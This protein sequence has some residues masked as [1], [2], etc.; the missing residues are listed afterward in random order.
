MKIFV[1]SLLRSVERR[2]TVS[3]VMADHGLDFEFIDG[4]DGKEGSHP[5]LKKFKPNKFLVRHGRP[6]NPGEGGCYASHYLAWEK[7]IE[8]DEPIIVFE[9]DFFLR[10]CVHDVFAKA[11]T[12]VKRYPFIRLED[13][14]PI[15]QK[16]V[17]DTEGFELVKFLKIPQRATCYALSPVAAKAFVRHSEEFV[18]PVDVFFRHQNLH[19]VPFFGLSPRPVA[20]A[21]PAGDNSEIGNRHRDKGPAWCK[22]TKLIFKIKNLF[23]NIM[24]NIYHE[25]RGY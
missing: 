5:L 22:L 12:L 11:E 17:D 9:D 23:L 15:L 7:C 8:L 18:Y 25:I 2:A 14:G 20:P 3:K 6:S 13:N 4:V 1:L 19:R 24:T 16:V 21:D 10:E